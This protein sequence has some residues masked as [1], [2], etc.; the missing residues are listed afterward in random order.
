LTI[1]K[2]A[3]DDLAANFFSNIFETRA[4]DPFAAADAKERT[5]M[6]AGAGQ[7]A[8]VTCEM[9]NSVATLTLNRP[10]SRNALSLAMMDALARELE[11]LALRDDIRVVVLQA[12]GPAFCAGHDLKELTARRN[13][14]DLGHGF[15]LETMAACSA[16]MQQ[17]VSLPRPV[18]A[19]V[20][21]MASRK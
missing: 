10:S 16:L 5:R 2:L 6:N 9:A 7:T 1:V 14:A 18:I 8:L 13:D 15:F 4:A 21:E 19:A 12:E 17:I 3:A 20:D 11:K